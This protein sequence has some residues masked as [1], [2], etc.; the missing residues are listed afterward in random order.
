MPDSTLNVGFNKGPKNGI[1]ARA[2]FGLMG[3]SAAL[4]T[5][6]APGVP[7]RMG[8]LMSAG[9]GGAYVS[10]CFPT[11]KNHFREGY[12]V[13]GTSPDASGWPAAAYNFVISNASILP[14]WASGTFKCGFIGS[15]TPTAYQHST[16]SNVVMGN[17]TST[18]TT[19]D[20]VAT[21]ASFGYSNSAAATNCFCYLP[22]YPAA[23]I[24]DPTNPN[25]I[26]TEAAAFYGQFHHIRTEWHGIALWNS[27]L[28]TNSNRNA[29]SNTQTFFQTNQWFGNQHA[30]LGGLPTAGAISSTLS[31]WT[32]GAGTW[33]FVFDETGS[34]FEGRICTVGAGA[35]PTISWD[36]TRGLTANTI[37]TSV[38]YGTEGYPIEWMLALAVAANTGLVICEPTLQDGTNNVAG[39]Y[40]AGTLAL[41]SSYM[42]SYPTWTGQV[43]LTPGNENWNGTYN[44]Y[45]VFTEAAALHGYAS[46][47]TY[48]AAWI[49]A[50]ANL[51]R[52]QFGSNFGQ[53]KQVGI[54]LEWQ[55]GSPDQFF[56]TLDYMTNTLGVTP[57]A[58]ISYIATAPYM[59]PAGLSGSSTIANIVASVNTAAGTQAATSKSENV[60]IMGLHYGIPLMTYEGGPQWNGGGYS[61]VTNLGA[62]IMDATY[63]APIETYY[64]NLAN[65]GFQLFSHTTYGLTAV[66]AGGGGTGGELGIGTVYPPTAANTPN[67]TA[68]LQVAQNNPNFTRNVISGS[69]SIILGGSYADKTGA[70]N[71]GFPSGTFSNTN[72]SPYHTLQGYV[73]WFFN[74]TV[75]GTYTLAITVG[76]AG[77]PGTNV[78]IGGLTGFVKQTGFTLAQGVNSN[79]CTVVI[80]AGPGYILLGNGTPQS[81]ATI[82]QLQFN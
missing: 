13:A 28:M 58:D 68:L 49:H 26:T 29:P 17:G 74:C 46:R 47:Q 12:V 3:L 32:R 23:V 5:T 62:A 57:S 6:A 53:G 55:D 59:N 15:G 76:G 39:S 48:G 81:T 70:A 73:G 2:L 31:G 44:S 71:P 60:A 45:R 18:Y 75:G 63:A 82:S 67:V 22:A 37:S 11:W 20:L 66:L 42:A 8:G 21:A 9:G 77:T 78:E 51:G 65:G 7:N 4:S 27:Q 52:T 72:G 14:T 56:S 43:L 40:S 10:E 30:T 19:F 54:V 36:S 34:N 38:G 25:S 64:N 69:G 50:L 33:C 24:D 80:P 41:V 35:N 16:V 79:V 61:G 1:L